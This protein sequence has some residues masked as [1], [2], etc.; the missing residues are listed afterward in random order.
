MVVEVVVVLMVVVVAAVVVSGVSSL[1]VVVVVAVVGTGTYV[2]CLVLVRVRGQ[3]SRNLER[4]AYM[5]TLFTAT[6]FI[7]ANKKRLLSTRREGDGLHGPDAGEP[8][9]TVCKHNIVAP[10]PRDAA[11][12]V[13]RRR[14]GQVRVSGCRD[15]NG[16][17][18]KDMDW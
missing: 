11:E 7:A 3:H 2:T 9:P 1:E 18:Q 12:A 8:P 14:A 4:C 13:W 17:P 5:S 10:R 15:N 6:L 16:Q